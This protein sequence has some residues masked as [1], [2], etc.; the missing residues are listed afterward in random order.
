MSGTGDL[1]IHQ[2]AL[3]TY[4]HI[5]DSIVRLMHPLIEIVIHDIE[6]N[7]IIYINGS[8]S[9]RKAGDPSLLDKENLI[10][11]NQIIYPKINFDGRLV[12]SVSII[13]EEQWLLCINSDISVFGKMQELG[14]TLLQNYGM[15]PK[16]LFKNDWQEK[17]HISIHDYLQLHNLTFEHITQSDK[18]A[19]VQYLFDL[20]AFN[21]KNAPDYIAKTLHLG[22]A[23]IFNYLKEWR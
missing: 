19:L 4:I 14:Q 12:K 17:L 11:V 22:R 2:M 21:E 9:K 10:D 7:N 13:L 3:S 6:A 5:A 20:G 18:K 15:Q 16:A 1:K 23:T 8:L